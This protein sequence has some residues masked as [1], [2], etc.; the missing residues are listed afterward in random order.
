[1]GGKRKSASKKGKG[2][3]KRKHAKKTVRRRNTPAVIKHGSQLK[4]L[5]QCP[6]KTRK[7]VIQNGDSGLINAL[8]ECALNLLKGRVH[9]TKKQR[10]TLRR[11]KKHLRTLA[12]RKVKIPRK[13]KILQKGGFLPALL[14]PFIG[15]ALSLLT[16]AVGALAKKIFK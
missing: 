11:H 8:C 2:S 16:P 10:G 12:D 1:M 9:L 4:L 5:I 6:S 15:P 14:A 13:K 3:S 7:A